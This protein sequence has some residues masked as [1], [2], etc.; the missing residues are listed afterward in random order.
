MRLKEMESA[1]QEARNENE[2]LLMEIG[3]TI[4]ISFYV[5]GAPKI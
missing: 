5:Q 3:K 2:E 4:L 1:L